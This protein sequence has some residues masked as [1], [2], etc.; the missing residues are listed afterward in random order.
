M[1]FGV[2]SVSQVPEDPM[3]LPILG[4]GTAANPPNRF[5]GLEIVP[6]D[7]G[8]LLHDEASSPRTQFLR[9]HTRGIVAT[10]DS[11][12]VPFDASVNPYRGCEHGCVYCFARPTH[13]YLGYSSGLDFETR[14][15]VKHEAPELLRAALSA[16]GWRPR[17]IALSGVT[18]PYQP[19][20]RRLGLTRRCLEVLAAF[21]NPVGVVTKNHLVTRD[22]D[23]LAELASAGAAVVNLSVTTLDERLQ[24]SME[25]RASPPSGRLRAIEELSRAGVPV[26]VLVAPV[27]PGLTDHELPAIVAAAAAA[28]AVAA[29]YVPLRLPFALKELFEAWL[30][31]HQPA[32]KDRVLNRVREMHGGRLYDARWERRMRGEGVFAEQLRALYESA[33]RRAGLVERVP[34]SAEAFRVPDAGGQL[35]LFDGGG[36]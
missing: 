31:T 32:R 11:P 7:D 20:E 27:I 21:R 17:P 9:D 13:E 1:S 30:A 16:P 23:L 14:I 18:D 2:S 34:L 19:V 8:D 35:G 5:V 15:L 3:Q 22:A 29:G 10:N 24:R 6:A 25:P 4:R 33:C 26:R 36:S 28:G 12:D